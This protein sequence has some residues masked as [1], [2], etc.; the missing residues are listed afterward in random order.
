MARGMRALWFCVVA[1]VS[2]PLDACNSD[3]ARKE[4]EER[5]R[6]EMR[7]HLLHAELAAMPTPRDIHA[8]EPPSE[9][10]SLA[11]L[12]DAGL[13]GDEHVGGGQCDNPC[14][15]HKPLEQYGI[16]LEQLKPLFRKAVAGTFMSVRSRE[17]KVASHRAYVWLMDLGCA[18][19]Q[20]DEQVQ[21]EFLSLLAVEESLEVRL[22]VAARALYFDP[23]TAIPVLRGI[24]Q[25]APRGRALDA[26]ILLQDW[27]NEMCDVGL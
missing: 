27:E 17:D 23:D 19:V 22:A 13:P 15:K 14:R 26:M 9:S 25:S 1:L 21:R 6:K 11:A 20:S 2:S 12:P 10:I 24:A 18:V 5:N 16:E 3:R 8:L 7:E 4:A